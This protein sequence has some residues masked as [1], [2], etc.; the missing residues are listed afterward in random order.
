GIT[1]L[2]GDIVEISYVKPDMSEV[3]TDF[4][5]ADEGKTIDDASGDIQITYDENGERNLGNSALATSI[6]SIFGEKPTFNLAPSIVKDAQG[7]SIVRVVVTITVPGV[8]RVQGASVN[9]SIIIQNDLKVTSKTVVNLAQVF[10]DIK[11]ANFNLKTN[12]K[13][14][15]TCKVVIDANGG[16]DF[17]QNAQELLEKLTALSN[18]QGGDEQVVK[19]A[20]SG[21]NV[22]GRDEGAQTSVCVPIFKWTLPLAAGALAISYDA[23]LAFRFSFSGQFELAVKGSIDYDVNVSYTKA[24]GVQISST[25]VKE[26]DKFLDNIDLTLKGV[27]TVKVGLIQRLG[28]NILAGVLNIEVQAEIGNYNRLFGYAKTNNLLGKDIDIVGAVYFEGGFYYDVDLILAVRIGV[29]NIANTKIDITGG[30]IRMYEAG[31]QNLELKVNEKKSM[32][33]KS[34]ETSVPDYTVAVYNL[35]SGGVNDKVIDRAKMT[36]AIVGSASITD[37]STSTQTTSANAVVVDKL[38]MM[39]IADVYKTSKVEFT[40]SA[41]YTNDKAHMFP[42]VETRVTYDGTAL[43]LDKQDRT[44]DKATRED[45]VIKIA[46][47]DGMTTPKVVDSVNHEIASVFDANAKTLTID[48][49]DACC[50]PTGL[51]NLFVVSNCSIGNNNVV[52]VKAPLNIAVVGKATL[53]KDFD[54]LNGVY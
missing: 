8:V 25:N 48:N 15:T 47:K 29:I 2:S 12:I 17:V 18:G 13:N 43:S 37:T 26:S 35:V 4:Q 42:A 32:Q 1:Q 45:M 19:D 38:G 20:T 22:A 33:T 7:N 27:A 54:K 49:I 46:M 3:Y 10:E 36:Y 50:L 30:E 5:Y 28:L 14:D 23:D 53:E 40:V 11:D 34:F 41:V 51:N 16:Y 21:E 24:E 44:F 52:E 31:N 6:I 9:L 39:K